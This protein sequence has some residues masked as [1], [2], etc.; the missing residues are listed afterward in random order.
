MIPA[1]YRVDSPQDSPV[2]LAALASLPLVFA[3]WLLIFLLWFAIWAPLIALLEYAT[4]RWIMHKANRLLDPK[5]SQ[6]HAHGAHHRGDNEEKFVDM[7]L[8]NALL[9]T[10]PFFL[11]LAGWGLI[12]G[13]L[14]SILIP[15]AALV[16]WCFLYSYL[17][18]RMHR[19]IH[20]TEA[21]WFRS[22]GPLFRFFRDHHLKHHGNVHS[23][24][25]TVFPW[26]DYL[27]FTWHEWQVARVAKHRPTSAP[28][29]G[30]E[31]PRSFQQ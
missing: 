10:C 9:L 20:E 15:S 5:L 28:S 17:W 18:T 29:G 6:L 25:G 2:L 26:T 1:P 22:S 14:S 24:Y 27:F 23:N 7:P 30:D 31:L 13:S 21:N 8:K 3:N 19:A 16:F 4:H 11:P 12:A